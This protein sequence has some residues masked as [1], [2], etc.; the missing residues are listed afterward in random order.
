[1]PASRAR[2]KKVSQAN[3]VRR[4]TGP[5]RAALTVARGKQV[6]ITG[7]KRPAKTAKASK[8]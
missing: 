7:W 5:R 1:M 4:L 2:P 3:S 8:G 6:S